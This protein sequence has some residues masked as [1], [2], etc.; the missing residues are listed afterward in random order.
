MFP[1]TAPVTVSW[2]VPR[3]NPSEADVPV[4][5]SADGMITQ[6]SACSNRMQSRSSVAASGSAHTPK[7][8]TRNPPRVDRAAGI[9]SASAP[10]RASASPIDGSSTVPPG[11]SVSDQRLSSASIGSDMSTASGTEPT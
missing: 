4:T 11:A 9:R 10:T 5:L 6:S 8:S 2:G 3:V 1:S 7:P